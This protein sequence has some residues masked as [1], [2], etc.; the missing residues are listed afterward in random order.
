MSSGFNCAL[1][2]ISY[3][4]NIHSTR[5]SHLP[6][7]NVQHSQPHSALKVPKQPF[8]GSIGIWFLKCLCLIHTFKSP[9]WV[10][11]PPYPRLGPGALPR[12]HFALGEKGAGSKEVYFGGATANPSLREHI[13]PGHTGTTRSQQRLDRNTHQS[14]PC[15]TLE[16]PGILCKLITIWTVLQEKLKPEPK[17]WFYQR[18]ANSADTKG[19]GGSFRL[20]GTSLRSPGTSS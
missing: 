1:S 4:L 20:A 16:Y 18:E 14:A 11:L 5:Y 2:D 19:T 7:V 8:R 6:S 15:E 9:C 17:C 12:Q 10:F 13:V 3:Y